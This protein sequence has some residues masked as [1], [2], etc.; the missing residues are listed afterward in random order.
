MRCGIRPSGDYTRGQPRARRGF[1]ERDSIRANPAVRATGRG[2]LTFRNHASNQALQL[3]NHALRIPKNPPGSGHSIRCLEAVMLVA[4][5]SSAHSSSLASAAGALLMAGLVC[6]PAF[7]ARAQT[8][9]ETPTQAQAHSAEDDGLVLKTLPLPTTTPGDLAWDGAALWVSDWSD[10]VLFRCDPEDGR[11]LER[12]AAPCYRPRGMAWADGKLYICDDFAGRIYIFDPASGITLADYA[13][14]NGAGLGLAW[15]G[16]ALWLADNARSELYRLIPGDGTALTYFRAP[17]DEPSGLA[18]DGTYLWVAQ[19]LHDRIYMVAPTAGKAITSFVSPGPYPCGLAPAPGGRLWLADFAEGVVRLCAPREARTYQTRDWREA[20]MRMVYRLENH[21]PGDVVQATI[22]LA[23]PEV[24]T[25]H[26]VLLGPLEY[27]GGAPRIIRD[28]W[29]QE[30]ASFQR[31]VLKP[32]ERLEVGYFA[33]ARIGALNYI[34]IPEQTGKLDDIPKDIRSLYTADGERYQVT[35]ELVQSTAKKIV[36]D[37]QNPYWIAR[38]IFDWVIDALDYELV[39]GWD[40]PE[41]LIKRGTGSCS[42]YA[43]L[44]IALCRAAGLPARYEA[45]IAV[46]GDDVSVDDVH[47]RWAEVYLPNYGWVP[48]DP[49]GGDGGTPGG[50]VDAIGRLQ[51][52]YFVTTRSGGGSEA[53]GWDYNYHATHSKRGRC[54]VT[55]D[56][57]GLWRRAKEEGQ[58]VAPSGA[59]VKP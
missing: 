58:P 35:S 5:A 52:R 39:G 38:K 43:F 54:A 29:Q 19:R 25:E 56:E 37:E 27:L 49:S 20:E 41:T 26:M 42:E 47:H 40:V 46:R 17:Q 23:V 1:R 8:P 24:E 48:I 14:P 51:N 12:F 10:G 15:D 11:V 50:Q 4:T 6:A 45:G 59:V 13:T 31:D 34:L 36:G 16:Q 30:V 57:W 53:L 3:G 32:G 28:R 22:N 18:F 33:R 55:Q 21:G 9:T 7:T 44:Y 2:C